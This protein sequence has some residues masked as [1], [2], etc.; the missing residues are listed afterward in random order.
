VSYWYRQNLFL[1]ARTEWV[2]DHPDVPRG[3]KMPENVVHPLL[4]REVDHLAVDKQGLRAFLRE[5]PAASMR[6]I[7]RRGKRG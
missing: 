5:I 7:T 2:N 4:L 3:L 6:S 1:Y